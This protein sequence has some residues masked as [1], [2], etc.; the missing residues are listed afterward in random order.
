MPPNAFCQN[1]DKETASPVVTQCGDTFCY[2]CVHCHVCGAFCTNCE[3]LYWAITCVHCNRAVCCRH[4]RGEE[5]AS[6][7]HLGNYDSG[8]RCNPPCPETPLYTFLEEDMHQAGII[9]PEVRRQVIAKHAY[10]MWERGVPGDAKAHWFEAEKAFENARA[11]W[12]FHSISAQIVCPNARP[13][14]TFEC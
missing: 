10:R 8:V 7:Y 4:S 11:E 14:V 9:T 6:K 2:E 1:C 3:E 12:K 5:S 13:E